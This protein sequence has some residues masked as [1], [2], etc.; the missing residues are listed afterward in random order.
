MSPVARSPFGFVFTVATAAIFLILTGLAGYDPPAHWSLDPM[1][2]GRGTWFNHILW[3]HVAI[4]LALMGA[5]AIVAR[6]I[7]R[8]ID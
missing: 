2:W 3:S 5:A 7:N 8:R 1:S 6:R 4:G